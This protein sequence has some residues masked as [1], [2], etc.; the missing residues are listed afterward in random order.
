[1]WLDQCGARGE[2]F[3]KVTSY[4]W[5]HMYR[6]QQSRPHYLGVQKGSPL[7]QCQVIS[8]SK[9]PP[10]DTGRLIP[11]RSPPWGAFCGPG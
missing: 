4:C 5:I 8:P 6:P 3:M 9:V 10:A 11:A 2:C 1:M 7:S